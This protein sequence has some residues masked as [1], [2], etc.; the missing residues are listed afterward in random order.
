MTGRDIENLLISH[1]ISERDA[2]ILTATA[3]GESSFNAR[4]VN[5]S[6]IEHSIGLFQINMDVHG[7]KLERA[8][9]STDVNT[10]IEW[11]KNP[12][13]N[14]KMAVE[15][16]RERET[17]DRSGL[18]AWTVYLTGRWKDFIDNFRDKPVRNFT[19]PIEGNY[20]Q[21]DPNNFERGLSPWWENIPPPTREEI[22]E[23][24][25]PDHPDGVIPGFIQDAF[26]LTPEGHPIEDKEEVKLLGTIDRIIHGSIG[27]PLFLIGII[28]ILAHLKVMS[29][30]GIV[31]QAISKIV[32]SKIEEVK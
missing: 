5:H 6:A 15:V 11:L 1:G 12:I 9:G 30:S 10:W 20:P 18:R 19:T 29:I 27:I 16:Y 32:P 17:F 2:E 23:R 21:D 24:F 31:S 25:G 28:L 4:A 14:I 7:D 3:F 26:D 13:N 22:E 8:T